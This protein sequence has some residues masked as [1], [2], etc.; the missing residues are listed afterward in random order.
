[1]SAIV[2]E[3]IAWIMATIFA[4]LICYRDGFRDG[5]RHQ[6]N[7]MAGYAME[8]QKEFMRRFDGAY[9]N[10]SSQADGEGKR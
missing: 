3:R 10:R 5:L 6:R 1:M 4:S 9:R 2:I 8:A 7:I